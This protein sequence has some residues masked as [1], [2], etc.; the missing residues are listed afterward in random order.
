MKGFIIVG[1]LT[2]LFCILLILANGTSSELPIIVP[3]QP[4]PIIPPAPV[5]PKPGSKVEWIDFQ[6]IKNL[7][8]NDWGDYLTDIENHL[9]PS[10][11]TQYRVGDKPTWAHEITHGIH[12]WLNN[13][14]QKGREHY[15]LYVGHNKATKIKQPKFKI[16][17]VAKIIPTSLQK[18]RYNLY[19]KKQQGDWNNEP[20]YL[21]DEWVAYCNGAECGIELVS[22]GIYRPNKNDSCWGILEF[23]VYAAY[24]VM[25]Q[26]KHDPGY[27][28]KHMLEFLAWNMERGMRLYHESQQFPVYNW[29]NNQYLTHLQTS[30]DARE[31]REFVKKNYGDDW[32][33]EVFGF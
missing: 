15:F 27:D 19:L 21:W 12:S 17:D 11:G 3:P 30:T 16:S 2:P 31:F 33:K 32:S 5:K 25:A 29:D 6:P 26:E 13:N 20:V 1:V 23:N 24:V 4:Q 18:T 14:M 10:M 8:D 9:H 28:N 7:S 22:K